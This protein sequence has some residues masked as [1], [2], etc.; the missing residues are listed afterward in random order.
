M[1]LD[2]GRIFKGRIISVYTGKKK[3]PGGR[4]AY[5]EEVKH[6]GA[7]LIVPFFGD[8]IIFIRQYRGV[9]GRYIW[10]LPAGTLAPGEGPKTCAR[11][12]LE[13]ETGFRAAAVEKIG[14][15]YTTPGF[16][17]EKITIYRAECR[18]KGKVK[19][20]TDEVIRTRLLTRKEA[21]VLFEKGAITDSK[22]I[23][24]LAFAGV[25]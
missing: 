15:I 23:A 14:S 4:T 3:I 5:F 8:K 11:R 24:A 9:I 21:R 6:P 20:D 18:P 25:L 12:E 16:C 7:A 22:T 10:E 17:D 2:R 13:E 1:G 19:R